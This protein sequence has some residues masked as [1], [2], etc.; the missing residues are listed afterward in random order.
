MIMDRNREERWR[1][2]E[3][4]FDKPAGHFIY[5]VAV[6][7]TISTLLATKRHSQASKTKRR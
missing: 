7:I 2:R 4:S 1:G 6:G 5:K 3:G